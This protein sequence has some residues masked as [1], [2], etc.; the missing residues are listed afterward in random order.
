VRRRA[1]FCRGTSNEKP[2]KTL[3][4]IAGLQLC[5]H[6]HCQQS[7]GVANAPGDGQELFG[8]RLKVRRQAL[9]ARAN[10]VELLNFV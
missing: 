3:L 4:P 5:S 6:Q 2:I 8:H 9:K 7:G 1:V 10:T